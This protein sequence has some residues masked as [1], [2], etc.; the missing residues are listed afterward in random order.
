MIRVYNAGTDAYLGEITAEQLQFLVDQ[1]EEEGPGDQDYYINA[2]TIDMLQNAG[3]DTGLLAILQ[4][5]LGDGD[6][7]DIRWSEGSNQP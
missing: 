4:S 5:A 6:E 2:A 1:F 3:A 7:A